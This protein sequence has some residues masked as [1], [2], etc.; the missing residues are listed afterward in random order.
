M[1]M[2]RHRTYLLAAWTL[3]LAGCMPQARR[4]VNYPLPLT[5]ER[6]AEI[7]TGDAVVSYLRQRDAD[8][9]ICNPTGLGSHTS[10]TTSRDLEDLVDGVGRGV[11]LDKWETCIQGLLQS[12]PPPLATVIV[13]RIL[14]RYVERITYPRL[15][16]DPALL[17]QIE[18]VR[19]LY[20]QRPTGRDASPETIDELIEV[21]RA[22]EADTGRTGLEYR[23]RLLSVLYLERGLLPDGRAVSVADLDRMFQEGEEEPLLLYSRRMPDEG[24]RTD[25]RR[26]L[27]RLRIQS[28][29]YEELREYA[30]VVEARVM[31][32]G[33]MVVSPPEAGRRVRFIPEGFAFR[34]LVVEQQVREQI[35]RLLSFRES[36]ENVSVVPAVDLRGHLLFQVND[37]A[38]P[39]TLCASPDD[40]EVSPCIDAGEVGIGVP[41]AMLESNG[42]FRFA[43]TIA[44]DQVLDL[45]REDEFVLP[46]LFRGQQVAEARW[47]MRFR[48]TGP[49]AFQPGYGEPGPEVHVDVDATGANVIYTIGTNQPLYVVLDRDGLGGFGVVAAGG[50]GHPGE[51]GATGTPGR[52]G[53]AGRNASC[54]QGGATD[55]TDGGN[56]GPG[57]HG[58]PAGDGGSGGFIIATLR[59]RGARCGALRRDL[60]GTLAAPGGAAGVGGAAGRG[61]RAGPGGSGGASTTCNGVSL[62]AG[63]RGRDGVRGPDGRSGPGGRPGRRGRVS[64]RM[65]R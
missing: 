13:N 17:A 10:L 59:C 45:A 44:M 22:E 36:E 12:A 55:G 30:E 47:G 33:R 2:N 6:T 14:E 52:A 63:R 46:I 54:S 51:P 21:L 62:E 42:Q 40:F 4:H 20:D 27:V 31:A 49:I 29:E 37:F 24:L 11:H 18:S 32:E 53:R 28:S 16:A 34:G 56:G 26:R 39:I 3:A 9:A 38:R 15:D 8:P 23:N 57:G 48:T 5:G 19:R 60:A 41:F 58:G 1:P 7:N 61:G 35:A 25:A 65:T 64:I 50:D 43:E